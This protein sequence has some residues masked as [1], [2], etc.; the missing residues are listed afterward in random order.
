MTA[1]QVKGARKGLSLDSTVACVASRADQPATIGATRSFRIAT[2]DN[3]LAKTAMVYPPGFATLRAR[4]D[5]ERAAI[6]FRS[7]SKTDVP[8][9]V[10]ESNTVGIAPVM[11]PSR[12]Q[13]LRYRGDLDCWRMPDHRFRE[14]V[15]ARVAIELILSATGAYGLRFIAHIE[16]TYRS[17]NNN[18]CFSSVW[19]SWVA[20][21]RGFSVLEDNAEV[22]PNSFRKFGS[23][24]EGWAELSLNYDC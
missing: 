9:L 17:L 14:C 19:V 6:R 11:S 24:L 13:V 12:I 3:L 22:Q 7:A 20:F 23:K 4:A 10:T 16:M 18:S 15:I 5:K 8:E 2:V 21:G 1:S